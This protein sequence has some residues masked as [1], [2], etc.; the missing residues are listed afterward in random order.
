MAE[1]FV[2]SKQLTI[3][4]E[5][6]NISFP[7]LVHYPTYETSKPIAFGPYTMEVS[8]DAEMIE[9]Q[10]PLVIIS[11]GTGG[12]PL[13]YRTINT[14]LA[15]MGFIVVM[16]EHYGNN[17]LNNELE[18]KNENFTNRLRHIS[19]T[20][21]FMFSTNEFKEHLQPNNVAVIGHSIG[22]NTALVLAGGIPI[23][24]KDYHAK[25]GKPNHGVQETQETQLST[26]N[27]IRAIV[28]FAL[29]PGWFIGEDSLKNVNIPVLLLNA[30]KDDYIP[31]SQTELFF[32]KLSTNPHFSYR[33]IKNAGHFSFI[34]PFPESI[35]SKVGLP[36]TDPE[37][38]DREK[39]HIQL[40]IDILD[41][42][43]DKLIGS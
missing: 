21:D 43:N 29:T 33:I 18:G 25:F 40:P 41:F 38:F 36:S 3:K 17:R 4:D 2:G 30:E 42:L 8:P 10:F 32:E 34:S 11:H 23:S 24:Y 14:N 15:K 26:D 16:I 27:R 6:K 31:N 1:I 35:K 13:L 20:I 9:G 37:G 7:V 5:S 28:L 12:S 19:L 22:A 39:F